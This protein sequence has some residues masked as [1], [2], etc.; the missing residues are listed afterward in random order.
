M[1]KFYVSSL[2]GGSSWM[3]YMKSFGGGYTEIYGSL[4]NSIFNTKTDVLTARFSDWSYS[5]DYR[6]GFG[7]IA[8]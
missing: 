3:E 4:F 6:R 2:S 1:D 7:L 5:Y 8:V